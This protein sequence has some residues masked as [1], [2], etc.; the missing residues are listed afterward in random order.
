VVE[1]LELMPTD[2]TACFVIIPC[3]YAPG[4]LAEFLVSVTSEC[5]FTLE[6]I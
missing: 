3:T 6:E 5:P 4:K 1:E 2:D